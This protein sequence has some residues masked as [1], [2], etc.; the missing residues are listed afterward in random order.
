MFYFKKNF[1][2]FLA[3][4]F[5][6]TGVLGILL[7][8]YK[9]W[10]VN[11]TPI[12]LLTMF[13]LLTKSHIRQSKK[14]FAFFI[15]TFFIGMI[16]EMIGVN[17]GLL[18]GHYSYGDVLGPKLYGVPFLIGFNWFIIVFCASAFV[19]QCIVLLKRKYHLN[20][21]A[22]SIAICVV[23]GGAAIATCFDIILEPVAVKLNFWTWANGQIPMLN[24]ICWFII[25]AFLLM[26]S[27]FL[28]IV[29][30]NKFAT[31]LFIIEA[32]FFLALN[33]FLK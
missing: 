12:V 19:N 25:S 28:K 2:L 22:T 26:I 9:D 20:I 18:F 4:L 21:G 5:H 32:L 31:N 6:L 13:L 8:P 15:M 30:T 1:P 27:V 29:H 14:Y 11:N 16:T 23:I 17:T 33:I 24:Y 3:L 10:F 7:T